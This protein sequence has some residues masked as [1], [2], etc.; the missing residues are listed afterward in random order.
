MFLVRG[1]IAACSGGTPHPLN[2]EKQEKVSVALCPR[3]RMLK[4]PQS[5]VESKEAAATAPEQGPSEATAAASAQDTS[6][7]RPMLSRPSGHSIFSS[8]GPKRIIFLK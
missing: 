6:S 2:P 8:V 3:C 5:Q 1:R 7:R 4:L